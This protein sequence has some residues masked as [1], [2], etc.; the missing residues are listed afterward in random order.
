MK[1]KFNMTDFATEA[2]TFVTISKEDEGKI[3]GT[4]GY[5]I[6]DIEFIDDESVPATS[7]SY[8]ENYGHSKL[9]ADVDKQEELVSM[10]YEFADKQIYK[11]GEKITHK[12]MREPDN[13][14]RDIYSVGEY[15]T[16]IMKLFGYKIT[17]ID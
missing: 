3:I 6:E 2:K 13:K 4:N 1:I 5:Q 12:G 8:A 9:K 10:L 11:E 15:L 16:K 17:P 14:F 7:A